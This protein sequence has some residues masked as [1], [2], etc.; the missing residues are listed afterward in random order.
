MQSAFDLSGQRVLVTGAGGAIGGA[1]ARACAAQ[2]AE[3]IL[4]DLRA[5]DAL[6]AELAAEGVA[7]KAFAVDNT[8]Q[9]DVNALLAEVGPVDSLA[10]CS[11]FYVKGEWAAGG[12][13]WDDLLQRTM[14]VNVRGPVNLVRACLPGMQLRG[15]G[16]IALVGS[17]AARNAGSTL[18][19]EPAYAASKGALHTLV[20]Y[21][22]RQFAESNV[23]VN[24]IAPGPVLTPLLKSANQPFNYDAIPLRRLGV[25]EEIGWPVAFLCSRAVSYMTGS[26]IDVNGGIVFS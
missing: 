15:G 8:R 20:R 17:M 18:A 1:A 14:T 24:A 25:P 13:A 6:C 11:G 22:A 21:F 10:D 9:S 23:V 26:V 12:E 19:A 4:A 5:P 7:V 16:R 3:L 2:N